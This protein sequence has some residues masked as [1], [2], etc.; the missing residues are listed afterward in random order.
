MRVSAREHWNARYN[1]QSQCYIAVNII[2][3]LSNIA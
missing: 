2:R 3:L 1:D